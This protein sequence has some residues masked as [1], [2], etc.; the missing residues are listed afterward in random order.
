[1]AKSVYEFWLSWQ[2]EKEK[3][4]LPVLP[5]KLDIVFPT[6]HVNINI[7]KQGEIVRIQEPMA[8]TI[9]FSSFSKAI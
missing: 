2:Q 8:R 5:E 6:N 1:M 4:R 3:F 9:E 7:A